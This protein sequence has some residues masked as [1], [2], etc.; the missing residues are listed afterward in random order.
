VR[1]S[2]ARVAACVTSTILGMAVMLRSIPP[3]VPTRKSDDNV[4]LRV[5]RELHL[6][7]LSV[8]LAWVPQKLMKKESTEVERLDLAARAEAVESFVSRALVPLSILSLF[9]L[10]LAFGSEASFRETLNFWVFVIIAVVTSIMIWQRWAYAPYGL[11]ILNFCGAIGILLQSN[12]DYSHT[13]LGSARDRL[14]FV[15]FVSAGAAWWKNAASFIAAQSEEI[16]K[17]RRQV[18]RW[19]A[20]L[21]YPERSE[22]IVEFSERSFWTGHWTYRLL[23]TGHYWAIAKF[24]LGNLRRLADFRV[25]EKGAVHVMDQ[26]GE[27]LRIEI[28]SRPIWIAEIAPDMRNRLL[29]SVNENLK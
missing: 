27:K 12:D 7:G 6:V 2:L 16:E 17:E 10:L 25:Q 8:E 19:L 24:K 18:G 11:S 21:K 29:L 15:L 28:A 9:C 3:L 5:R 1:L 26:G 14:L 20:D 13:L 23:D 22:A 4:P